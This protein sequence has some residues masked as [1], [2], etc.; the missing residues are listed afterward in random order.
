MG[1]KGKWGGSLL[2]WKS[3]SEFGESRSKNQKVAP[4]FR[5]LLLISKTRSQRVPW[6]PC[7]HPAPASELN[8]AKIAVAPIFY[9]L[10]PYLNSRSNI[11]KVA[12]I[13]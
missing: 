2:F 1:R 5:N 7:A 8:V 6:H 13:F 12:P 9:K 4:I 3:C 10:I 11:S